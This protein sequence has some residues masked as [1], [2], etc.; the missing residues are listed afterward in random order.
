MYMSFSQIPTEEDRRHFLLM[1]DG[2]AVSASQTPARERVSN[3]Y[4]LNLCVE[5]R[6]CSGN[7]QIS[8]YEPGIGS[9]TATPTKVDRL[10]EVVFGFRLRRFVEIAYLNLSANFTQVDKVYIFGFSRGAVIARL[11]AALISE[12]GVLK[13]SHAEYFHEIWDYFVNGKRIDKDVIKQ[14]CYKD[15]HIE[16][17]G[18]FDSV[19]GECPFDFA[20]LFDKE[21][22]N[23]KQ[24]F[25]ETRVLPLNVKTAVQILALDENRSSFQPVLF[26]DVTYQKAE[27]KQYLE[28]IWMPGVHTDVGGGYR[29]FS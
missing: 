27:P 16:F 6:S 18:L 25:A 11:V 17:L 15:V 13:P 19:Y 8:F 23:V 2:S 5:T 4:K 9:L 3:I 10:A 22:N 14:N 20:R 21:Y 12:F 1:I 7:A 24:R 26:D 29:D 28:Q